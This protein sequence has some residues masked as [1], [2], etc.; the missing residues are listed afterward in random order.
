MD[1][2][3]RILL[4]HTAFLGDIVLAT[5]LIRETR[6][7]FPQAKI[8]FL[9]TPRTY[10]LIKHNPHLDDVILFDKHHQKL[11]NFARLLPKLWKKNY[12]LAITPHS[13]LTTNFLML[14]AGIKQR[15]GFDRYRSRRLLT[16]R[17]VYPKTGHVAA[18]Y[19]SLLK[20][21]TDQKLDSETELF[22][23][24]PDIE[25]AKKWLIPGKKPILIAPG[26]VWQTKKLP[27]E[28]Y[29]SISKLLVAAGYDLIFI[30]S[31]NEHALSD[32]IINDSKVP[33]RNSCGKLKIMESAALISS[34]KLLITND[35]G[36]LHLANAVN[37][38]VYAFFGP[39]IKEFGYFPYRPDDKVFEVKLNCRPCGM[40]GNMKC[41]LEHH[42]CLKLIQPTE[43]VE[44]IKANF[45]P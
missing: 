41:P 14:F 35:S 42:N 13:H 12:D 11:R 37:T 27:K 2:F 22:L 6:R 20:P 5:A 21:F 8:D 16:T 43:V 4:L 26:S 28:H 31:K 40:H 33:A 38:P 17:V 15:V 9:T 19:L 30:G 44:E 25:A 1:K 39:T 7:T 45:L 18:R 34:A 24:P 32:W 23:I 10:D 3:K 29:S 36:P